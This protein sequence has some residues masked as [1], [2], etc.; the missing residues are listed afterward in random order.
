MIWRF[1]LAARTHASHAWNTG[2][3]PVGATK[4][5]RNLR[6]PSLFYC[7]NGKKTIKTFGGF[8]LIWIS[9]ISAIGFST[10]K[11]R[12][13]RAQSQMYLNYAEAPP[14]LAVSFER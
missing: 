13:S 7:C 4:M 2:S 8:K 3:I 14:R 12:A 5:R 9:F 6:I 11:P 10:D 1:R